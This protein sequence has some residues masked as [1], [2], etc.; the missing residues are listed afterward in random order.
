M[1]E[2]QSKIQPHKKTTGL[3][4]SPEDTSYV[5]KKC[6]WIFGAG[7]AINVNISSL[8][9]KANKTNAFTSG[10]ATQPSALDPLP[11]STRTNEVDTATQHRQDTVVIPLLPYRGA[12][13]FGIFCPWATWMSARESFVARFWSQRSD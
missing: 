13:V 4:E 6:D 5:K 11:T 2:T 8:S 9:L 10:N 12:R 3:S 1:V 7:N